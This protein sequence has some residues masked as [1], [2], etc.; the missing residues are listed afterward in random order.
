MTFLNLKKYP[1]AAE[2]YEEAYKIYEKILAAGLMKE[3]E[4]NQSTMN[5]C[6]SL[7]DCMETTG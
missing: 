7:G 1:Q 3:K 4:F 6:G 2:N 5:I